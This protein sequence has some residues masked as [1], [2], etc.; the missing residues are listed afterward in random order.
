M[1]RM[2][3]WAVTDPIAGSRAACSAPKHT[4]ADRGNVGSSTSRLFTT[5]GGVHEG[6]HAVHQ[7]RAGN[8]GRGRSPA[9]AQIVANLEQPC[10][11]VDT[12]KRSTKPHEPMLRHADSSVRTS[13]HRKAL[14]NPLQQHAR[15]HWLP[16]LAVAAEVRKWTLL[17][18]RI[19]RRRCVANRPRVFASRSCWIGNRP[20]SVGGQHC[21]HQP[22]RRA[23][24]I[25]FALTRLSASGNARQ[26]SVWNNTGV[27]NEQLVVF[28]R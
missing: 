1:R 6:R 28:R 5:G 12:F 4:P 14:K 19:R 10:C 21:S 3:P 8:C 2:P 24:L 18:P 7:P 13:H 20:G 22:M 16:P 26:P 11:H 9:L 27:L 15:T 17:V 23:Y 25:L